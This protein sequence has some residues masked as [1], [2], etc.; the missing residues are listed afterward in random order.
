[1][2]M[3]VTWTS[4]SGKTITATLDDNMPTWLNVV[5]DGRGIGAGYVIPVTDKQASAVAAQC[6]DG[7]MTHVLICGKIPVGVPADVAAKI[8]AAQKQIESCPQ[9]LES[10]RQ[11][12]VAT[13]QGA[14][15]DCST[16]RERAFDRDT[17]EGWREVN[18]AEQAIRTAEKQLADFDAAHPEIIAAITAERDEATERFLRAD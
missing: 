11:L 3:T 14:S 2:G 8:H 9:S 15:D 1:M 10:Q 4:K 16:A 18:R 5:V 13:I 6:T 17:G 12:L 7:G